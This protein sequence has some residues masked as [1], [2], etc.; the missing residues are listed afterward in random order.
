VL[1]FA[2]PVS[3]H[4][5]KTAPANASD[6]LPG[7]VAR[8]R[9][10]VFRVKI[11]LTYADV[12]GAT[13]PATQSGTAFL[14]GKLGYAL[15]SAHVVQLPMEMPGHPGFALKDTADRATFPM[16]GTQAEPATVEVGFRI[17]AIDA[18]HDLALLRL[19]SNPFSEEFQGRVPPAAREEGWHTAAAVLDIRPPLDGTAI[20]LAGF[21]LQKAVMVTNSGIIAAS[22]TVDNSQ[23]P[24]GS[25][26]GDLFLADMTV[27]RGNSGGPVF[28]ADTG[29]VI[30]VCDA[31]ER[32]P[33]ELETDT[34]PATG[35]QFY[36][37][38]ISTIVPA[39]YVAEFL[40]KQGV[41]FEQAR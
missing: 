16:P 9:G 19:D 1:W 22:E 13:V 15:T 4:A 39:K 12:H 7:S 37:S 29:A 38:G 10:A 20:A 31:F 34:A 32:A 17:V 11:R 21:P 2:L 23:A 33:L 14:V 27:N 26:Y 40:E 36:N 35:A 6:P 18:P 41:A 28:R 24:A 30:G 3:V 25:H 5:Q 8:L